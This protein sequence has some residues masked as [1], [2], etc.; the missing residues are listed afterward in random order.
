MRTHYQLSKLL[1]L[2]EFPEWDSSTKAGNVTENMKLDFNEF[3]SGVFS[4]YELYPILNT[5][6][7][8]VYGKFLE[9]VVVSSLLH[10]NYKT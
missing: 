5:F 10:D 2:C 1:Q 7:V 6:I 8:A 3:N 9:N 4:V